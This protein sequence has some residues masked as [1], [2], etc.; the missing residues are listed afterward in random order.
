LLGMQASII[1]GSSCYFCTSTKTQ[2]VW[3]QW[4]RVVG[5]NHRCCC[6]WQV[7]CCL[8]RVLVSLLFQCEL[9]CYFISPVD[10]CFGLVWKSN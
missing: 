2:Y 8:F 1:S 10:L 6:W 3:T 4:S 7:S 5:H 9:N